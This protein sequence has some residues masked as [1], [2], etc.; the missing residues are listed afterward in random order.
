VTA[1]LGQSVAVSIGGSRLDVR[2][3][4]LVAVSVGSGLVLVVMLWRRR[5]LR[6]SHARR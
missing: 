1:R 6:G 4:V 3:T 2:R 5:R